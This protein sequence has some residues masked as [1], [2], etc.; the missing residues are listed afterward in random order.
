MKMIYDPHT[1]TSW[2]HGTASAA[3]MI[4]AAHDMGLKGIYITE[5]GPN[6]F[7][8]RHMTRESYLQLRNEIE[9]AK[10]DY[11]DMDIKYGTEANIISL[12]GDIDIDDSLLPV[13]DFINV[14]YHMMLK[15]K[16]FSSWLLLF[17]PAALIKKCR[18][19]FLEKSLSRRATAA[20]AAALDKYKINMI[21]HPTSNY[22]Q[23]LIAIAEK[24][25]ER[26]TVL[27]INEPRCLLNAEQLKRLKDINVN[28]A[29]GS[30]AHSPE[31]VGACEK[32]LTSVA[33]SG[34]PAER[35]LNIEF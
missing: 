15:W 20:M 25:A 32:A 3:E 23:D 28:F 7:Y 33:E 1:H 10:A 14:G 34:L 24:C 18:F 22:P 35:F 5:H 6:H 8:A 29:V 9:A 11:P 2:S 30:D 13:F 19:H 21:T 4:R 17:V 31:R 12:K 27:E 26:G 16:D